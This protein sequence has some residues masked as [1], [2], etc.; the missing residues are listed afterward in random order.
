MSEEDIEYLRN[1]NTSPGPN[2]G[3]SIDPTKP[4]PDDL[5]PREHQDPSKWPSREDMERAHAAQPDAEPKW[6][7]DWSLSAES[8]K[9][10]EDIERATVRAGDPRLNTI[11]GKFD[12]EPVACMR[13]RVKQ[14][15]LE[16]MDKAVLSRDASP[17]TRSRHDARFEATAQKYA[18]A[19]IAVLYA[20]PPRPDASA[21]L[22][23]DLTDDL[24]FA[25]WASPEDAEKILRKLIA[26]YHR[27]LCAV[28]RSEK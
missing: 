23:N 9:Q 26:K 3:K 13:E 7:G 16:K 10:L 5:L 8:R 25:E 14:A 18:D 22:I 1:I 28:D 19:A 15:I 6:Q 17:E 21:G 27:R 24:G 11:V 4:G 20:A 2:A 12:A